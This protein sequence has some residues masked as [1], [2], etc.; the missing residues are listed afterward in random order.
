MVVQ[1]RENE[2]SV[3]SRTNSEGELKIARYAIER[4]PPC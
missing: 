3:T 1:T 4:M 2:C